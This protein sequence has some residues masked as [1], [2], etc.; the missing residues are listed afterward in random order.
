MSPKSEYP[1]H[2]MTIDA[3]ANYA[4]R[5]YRYVE[6]SADGSDPDGLDVAFDQFE[7]RFCERQMAKLQ[8]EIAVEKATHDDDDLRDLEAAASALAAKIEARKAALKPTPTT[9]QGD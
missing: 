1:V 5:L 3:A 9:N 6:E 7:R 2:G 4:D 8:H